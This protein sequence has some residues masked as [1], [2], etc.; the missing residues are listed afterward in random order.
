MV[1]RPHILSRFQR[2]IRL[3]AISA[4]CFGLTSVAASAQEITAIDFNGDLIGK[5]IPDGNVV[6]FDNRLIGNVTADSLIVDT[7][8]NLIGG[9]VPQG[10]AIGNDTKVL[11][12]VSNDGSVRLPSGKIIGKTLPNGLVV[13]DYYNITGAVLF[14]GLIYSNS[15]ETVGRLSGDG[16][17]TDLQGRQVGFVSPSGNAYRQIKDDYTLGG[18]LISSKMVVSNSGEFIGSMVPGGAVSNFEAANIGRIRANGFAYNVDNQIIG[19]LV[20]SGYAFDDLGGYVGFVSYNGEV[21]NQGN[22]VGRVKAD[23]EIV[24]NKGEHLGFMVDFAATATDHNGRYLGRVMPNGKV[25]QSKEI[26]GSVGPRGVI[27][28]ADGKTMGHI[29]RTGPVYDYRSQLKGIS[30]SGGAFISVQGSPLG[31]IKQNQ[32][33]DSGGRIVGGVSSSE[34]VIDLNNQSLGMSNIDGT[35]TVNN[36]PRSVSPYGYVFNQSGEIYGRAV[37]TDNLYSINGA[38]LGRLNLDGAITGNGNNKLGRYTQSGLLIDERNRI[39]GKNIPSSYAINGSGSSLGLL[40]GSNLLLDPKRQIIAKIL[41]DHSV[42]MTSSDNSAELMPQVG[43]AYDRRVA[44][45]IDGNMLGYVN[46][47]GVVVDI[48]GTNIGKVSANSLTLDNNNTISGSAIPYTTVVN[49]NCV[50]QGV[51]TPE[52][53]VRNYREISNGRVLTNGQVVSNDGVTKAH[54]VDLNSVID[55]NGNIIGAVSINGQVTNYSDQNLG[56]A[57][58]RGLLQNKTG[59]TIGRIVSFAPVMSFKGDIIGRTVLDGTVVDTDNRFVGYLQPNDNINSKIGEPLGE[60]FRYKVAFDNANRFLGRVLDDGTVVDSQNK[61]IGKVNFDGYVISG[62]QKI[63]YALYD[64]YIYDNN[65]AAIGYITKDGEVLSFSN[66]NLGRVFKGFLV[67]SEDKLVGRGARSYNIRGQNNQ[68]VGELSFDGQVMNPERKVI[69]NLKK[70]SGE[71]LDIDQKVV[72]KANPLQYYNRVALQVVVDANGNIVGYLDEHGNV[73]DKEGNIIGYR[74]T[75]GKLLDKDG[76]EY[77]KLLDEQKIFNSDGKLVGFVNSE[78]V[79][80]DENG[81]VIGRLNADGTV[82]D[83]SNNII[84]GIS[85]DWYERVKPQKTAPSGGNAMDIGSQVTGDGKKDDSKYRRS[86]NIALTPDG[87]Y[88]GEVLEDG[89]VVNKQGKEL[90]QKMPDGLIIDKDGNLIGIEEVKKPDGGGI[91]VPA[92]TFG[93]GEAYGTGNGPG[94]DLGPGGGF[95]PG[96]RYDPQRTR[97]LSYAQ[98]ERRKNM[99]VGKLSSNFSRESFDGMQKDWGAQGIEKVISSWRVDMSEMILADKPIPAVI[100][101]S[102]D[103]NHP[104][105]ITAFVE[106]NVYAEEGRNIL[107]PAGSRVIGTLGS[108]TASTEKTS[109]SAKIEITWERLIRPDGSL[110]VFTGLTGDAQGRGGALGYLDQQLFKR[111][112]LPVMTTAVTSLSSYYMAPNDKTDGETE[113]SRQQ[114]ANDARQNFLD[115]MNQVFSDILNDKANIKP[116]TYIPAG[117]RIIIYPTYDLWLRTAEREN[118]KNTVLPK[119]KVLIDTKQRD[120]EDDIN[121]KNNSS[122]SAEGGSQ[123]VYD[124]TDTGI[125]PEKQGSVLI[126][127]RKKTTVAPP[128]PPPLYNPNAGAAQPPANNPN[129]RP[130]SSSGSN[131]SSGG[132]GNSEGVPQLF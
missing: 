48:A 99:A 70:S 5:V 111:Y 60:L 130:A 115:Q 124:Q 68:V 56:C 103:S 50:L 106:R 86:F 74:N 21:T 66:R 117:T 65:Y 100:A 120:R 72:A 94:S 19:G 116:M 55:F 18:R 28:D 118:D 93:Q 40:S 15:G 30:L 108:V 98:A 132:S 2:L 83:A 92:G 107:I 126:S 10:V 114:A 49:Q 45:S 80:V 27:L 131:T 44:V 122:S 88:L 17:Y 34:M 91:F 42:V 125:A 76:K 102:I 32:A 4:L 1:S 62:D 95:G 104:T 46:P 12:K 121:R 31:Y 38:V 20:P 113:T 96:E 24:N 11:G 89:K 54:L 36:T 101:R 78:G 41:P 127:D 119:A 43:W 67:N 51:V 14:P 129:R 9:V 97:A 59:E 6:S 53:L 79:A 25:A 123:V 81:K 57:D 29:L 16:V 85:L 71:V 73:V 22:V 64:F 61:T 8:G 84:G 87:E 3:V 39:L 23:R 37:P 7:S 77:G 105:P 110:F 52:G 58:L 75:E 26:V 128:P 82:S 47:E 112:T 13:D 69:G 33:Y 63:G 90:G 35:I 109:T